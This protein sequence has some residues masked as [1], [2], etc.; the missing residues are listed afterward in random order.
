[1]VKRLCIIPCGKKKIWD[2]DPEAGIMKAK[3]VYRSALH[4]KCQAY[5]R[6]FFDHWAILSAKY[7]LLLPDDIVPGNY[8]VSFGTNHSDLI[9][10]QALQRQVKEKG[11]LQVEQVVMLGGKKFTNVVPHIFDSNKVN[12]NYPLSD[13]KGIGYMLQKLDY[14]L[15]HRVEM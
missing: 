11:L 3:H 4:R 5:A 9:S 10:F 1:M 2:D 6:M 8:D 7:G 13:C 12:I 14:A 15:K